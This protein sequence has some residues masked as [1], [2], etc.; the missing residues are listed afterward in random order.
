MNWTH[1]SKVIVLAVLLAVSLG[2]AGTATA[3]EFD[4]SGV[5]DEMEVGQQQTA[6]VV[7][8]EPFAERNPGW[9]LSVDSEFED[10]GVTITAT[11]PT[12]TIQQS[13][14]GEANL[15]LDNEAIDQVE[16]EVTG[17]VPEIDQYSYENPDQEKFTAVRV[18][19]ADSGVIETW[20]VKR[21]TPE[22]QEARN[23]ID[24]ASEYANEDDNNFQSA[25]ELYNSGSFE[26]ATTEADSIIESQESS[27]QTQ[28]MLFV[29]VGVVVLL[30]LVGGGYYVYSQR[31]Q[32]T[33][34]L[35]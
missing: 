5:N 6:T 18:S 34:K 25:V 12:E 27:E 19:D 22:S 1:S 4:D 13:G 24:E 23:R 3:F 15:T 8:E 28:T 32:N 11:T 33:N 35:Q 26:Q 21:Y 17:T 16:I 7:M 10:A 2:A 30:L 29:G 31:S 9:T 20:N 14:E